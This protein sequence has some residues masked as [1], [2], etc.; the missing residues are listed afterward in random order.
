MAR[1][2]RVYEPDQIE[3]FLHAYLDRKIRPMRKVCDMARGG[4]L[5]TRDGRETRPF[6]PNPHTF[7]GYVARERRRRRGAPR[8]SALDR[9]DDVL[10]G[11]RKRMIA[12]ADQELTFVERQRRGKRDPE[13]LRQIARVLREVA[14]LP[15][16]GEGR[17]R[18]PGKRDHNG[19]MVD[20]QT[21]GGIAGKLLAAHRRAPA[22]EPLTAEQGQTENTDDSAHARIN[23][24]DNGDEPEP[25]GQGAEPG[26]SARE[27]ASSL[28]FGRRVPSAT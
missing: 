1:F 25:T 27:T 9:P 6:D 4:Q 14:A 22:P 19:V 7:A 11:L 12:V 28:A 3:A 21:E 10:E 2:D 23:A 8:G 24:H 5:L 17:G 18:Q 13:H 16:P 20:G 15:K 26:S